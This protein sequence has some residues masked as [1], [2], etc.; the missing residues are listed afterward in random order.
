MAEN[1]IGTHR[2]AVNPYGI[3]LFGIQSDFQ[4]RSHAIR[5]TH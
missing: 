4:F 2:K 1:I 5:S 3:I